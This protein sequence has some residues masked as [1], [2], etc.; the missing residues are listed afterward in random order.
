M[1]DKTAS[2][3]TVSRALAVLAGLALLTCCGGGSSSTPP[4]ATPAVTLSATSLTFT[5][6]FVGSTSAAQPVTVSNTGNAALSF[7]GITINGDFAESNT[8]GTSISAS[9]VCTISVTFKP[10]AAGA[11]TGTLTITDNASGSPHMV[12]LS[13]TGTSVSVSPA[14]LSFS[15]TIVGATSAA[16]PVT[17]TNTNNVALAVSSIAITTGATDFAQTN[18]CGS[19]VAAAGSCTINVTFTPPATGTLTGTLTITDN[20]DG[21]AGSTQTVALTGT[22]SGSNTV[23]VTV[24]FGPNG[25]S[26]PS[27]SYY[28]G[29]FATV[30]VC[31]PGTSTCT[32]VPN[33]LVDTGS[34]GLRILSSAISTLTLPQVN[35]G[36]GDNLYECFE[37]GSL[38]YTWGPVSMATVQIGGEVASQ[39]PTVAGGTAN[40][41]IPIQVITA[42]ATA[43]A[44]APCLTNSTGS[45]NSVA[46]LGANGLL[47]I[48]N[49]PQ[50]CGTAC[51]SSATA[52]NV[53]PY[54][55]I[56]CTGSGTTSCSLSVVPLQDQPWNPISAFSSADTNGAVLQL[57]SVP[58]GGSPSVDGTLIF[59]IGTD[60]N[61]AIPGNANVYELDSVGNF[62][63]LVYNG[64]TYT[65]ANSVGSFLDSGSNSLFVS[66]PTTLSSATGATV[67]NCADNGYYCVSPS[68][69][70]LNIMVSGSNNVTS[71]T[72]TLS[73]ANADTLL[74]STNAALNN[75]GA[76]SGGTGTATDSWDLGLPF[77]FGRTIF[78]GIAGSSTTYPNGYWAF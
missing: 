44:G 72:Q 30:T 74:T 40:S 43:P 39:V 65:T 55:Y 62:Q 13:G 20:A 8:C 12:S 6:Q 37:F 66:D 22:S 76:T 4:A 51:T 34:T 31:Q 7:S 24:G 57:P 75:L 1:S 2:F 17:L 28:N 19:S 21:A 53:N 10:T 27:N 52:V 71:P 9:G 59:G 23:P 78:V 26:T 14:T 64:V 67:T 42:N 46:S 33:V 18:N 47:G 49:F 61:N 41:G 68:P 45:M 35:D 70:S 16:Q 25:F 5:G 15:G 56:I 58:A 50:D 73:I 3:S 32:A 69:L 48:G 36:T 11:R 77:F 38:S 29:I 63:S 60:N 54:P